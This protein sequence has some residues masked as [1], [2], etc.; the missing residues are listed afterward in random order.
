MQFR[1]TLGEIQRGGGAF[2][3]E[4][5]GL[6]ETLNQPQGAV[7]QKPCAAILGDRRCGFDLSTP[8]Y[9]IEVPVERVE[10]ARLFDFAALSGFD[11]RWFEKGRLRVLSGPAAGLTGVVKN[12]RSGPDGRRIELWEAFRA[13][14]RPGDDVRLEA[15]CDKRAITCR[16]KFANFPNFRGFPHIPGED[17]LM[18]YPVSSGVN[19]G[20]SL[21]R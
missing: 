11:A 12:D 16:F 18:S 4:L 1:G 15:G 20:G 6:T 10:G 5:R 17:W 2:E 13:E 8:G 3:A 7:F 21:N 19:D 9:A 14:V